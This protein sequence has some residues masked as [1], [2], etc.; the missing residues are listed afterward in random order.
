MDHPFSVATIFICT[1]L[2]TGVVAVALTYSSAQKGQERATGWWCCA[3][4]AATIGLT[5]LSLRSVLPVWFATGVGNALVM[6]AY[7]LARKGY[8]IFRNVAISPLT[9]GGG[10]A[11]WLAVFF[12]VEQVRDNFNARLILSSVIIFTYSALIAGDAW[13]G[14]KEEK[15]PSFLALL[16]LFSTHAVMHFLRASLAFAFPAEATVANL[17]SIW[18]SVIALENYIHAIGISFFFFALTKE[19]AERELTDLFDGRR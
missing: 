17:T 11:V 7:G 6:L 13:R 4:W 9:I 10:A 12:G 16:V 2:T 19:R 5:L 15:L 18:L 1:A 14:W 8:G 3:L